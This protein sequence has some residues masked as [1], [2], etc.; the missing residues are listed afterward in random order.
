MEE[1][2]LPEAVE[3]SICPCGVTAD[4]VYQGLTV[5]TEDAAVLAIDKVADRDT[6]DRIA[7]RLRTWERY[8][9][10]QARYNSRYG[11]AA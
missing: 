5:C 10:I 7:T 2:A 4:V 11:L 9:A 6:A 3:G 1:D 8:S